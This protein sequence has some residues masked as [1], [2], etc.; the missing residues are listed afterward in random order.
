MVSINGINDA[1]CDDI[2]MLDISCLSEGQHIDCLAYV[3]SCNVKTSRLG[4]PFATFYLKDSHATII[5]AR[6]F[7]IGKG[8]DKV[9]VF[10][11]HP[12]RL[13]ADVQVYNGAYSLVIDDEHGICIHNGDFDYESFIGKYP[14]DLHE[15]SEVYSLI[16]KKEIPAGMYSSLAVDFLGSG[17][18]GAFAMIYNMALS[19]LL[20]TTDID[21]IDSDSLLTVFFTVMHQL[22]L[23]LSRYNKFGSLERLML[24]TEYSDIECDENYRYVITD[25]LRSICENTKPL[26]LH[27][28]IIKNA[29]MNAHK[30]LQMIETNNILVPGAST[31][32]YFTD[33]LGN[34]INGG[35]ELLKY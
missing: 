11:R 35:V 10:A 9:Q 3:Q 1:S 7:D 23:I 2:R 28:H 13:T 20:F 4:K 31:Q 19:N 18:I 21:S 26:H 30:T 25:A 24:H 33:M 6:L 27:A 29:V 34:S 14:V 22:Y 16:M 5:A 8:K 17:K 12:V 15:A 32:M